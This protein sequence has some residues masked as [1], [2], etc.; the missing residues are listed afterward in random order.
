MGS[1]F[2]LRHQILFQRRRTWKRKRSI[3]GSFRILHLEKLAGILAG[4]VA[5]G[6]SL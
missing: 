5:A 2:R 4:I 1:S 6:T 3:N